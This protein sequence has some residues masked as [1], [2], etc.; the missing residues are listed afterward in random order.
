MD[1]RRSSYSDDGGDADCVEVAMAEQ[2]GIRDS[3]SPA[4]E[5]AVDLTAW[6]AL[7]TEL[8]R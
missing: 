3:K 7:L 5:L 8:R 6:S 2:V 4:G 1:C